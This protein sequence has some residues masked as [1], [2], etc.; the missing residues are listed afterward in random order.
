MFNS[1]LISCHF[2]HSLF[3]QGTCYD[4]KYPTDQTDNNWYSNTFLKVWHK[5]KKITQIF[6]KT[7][8]SCSENKISYTVRNYKLYLQENFHQICFDCSS[9]KALSRLHLNLR[10]CILFLL[11]YL[12][13]FIPFP[14]DY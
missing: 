14:I 4:I 1:I 6:C 2:L 5:F 10:K 13:R 12:L 11:L 9:F 8:G 3:R 7:D